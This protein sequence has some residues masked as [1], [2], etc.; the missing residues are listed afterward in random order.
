MCQ[1]PKPHAWRGRQQFTN[2]RLFCPQR[3]NTV[4]G[5]GPRTHTVPDSDC[6]PPGPLMHT[7][8]DRD[9]A[10]PGQ[11]MQ[12]L[13]KCAPMTAWGS[14]ESHD[15]SH[16]DDPAKRSDSVCRHWTASLT[17]DNSSPKFDRKQGTKHSELQHPDSHGRIGLVQQLFC[18]KK[19]RLLWLSA[20]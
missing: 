9:C 1:M 12:I 20:L 16:C 4:T 15:M 13:C 14:T 6:V 19:W 10:P 2:S 5:L 3:T 8:P 17:N 11:R 7:V 18:A